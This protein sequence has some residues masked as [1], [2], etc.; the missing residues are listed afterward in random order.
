MS[1]S[2]ELDA[3]PS[4]IG[5]KRKK[6][7][8]GKEKQEEEEEAKSKEDVSE[9]QSHDQSTQ[10]NPCDASSP[11]QFW[12]WYSKNFDWNSFSLQQSNDDTTGGH[13]QNPSA[14]LIHGDSEPEPQTTDSLF[15][16]AK[17]VAQ[18]AGGT[19]YDRELNF[20]IFGHDT[21]E[22]LKIPYLY[23]R[24][25]RKLPAAEAGYSRDLELL[26]E[27]EEADWPNDL[28][29]FEMQVPNDNILTIPAQMAAEYFTVLSLHEAI[30]DEKPIL[31]FTDAEARNWEIPFEYHPEEQAFKNAIMWAVISH[32]H[33]LKKSDLILFYRPVPRLNLGHYLIEFDR[34]QEYED[35]KPEFRPENFLFPLQ[36]DQNERISLPR[37]EVLIHLPEVR[38]PRGIQKTVT[39]KL[40]DS[41][42][43][44][45][46]MDIVRYDVSSYRIV[47]GWE[48]FVQKHELGATDV[49]RF[50]K[51]VNPSHKKHFLIEI[52]KN[53]GGGANRSGPS[54]GCSSKRKEIASWIGC[55]ESG[56]RSV[57]KR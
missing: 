52:V 57:A 20:N 1:E 23:K 9:E 28:F 45:W 7:S 49:I 29:L 32:L 37:V 26:L 13:V 16:E 34:R 4:D 17:K 15:E 6:D 41:Q 21:A 19:G 14:T 50:Y 38:I 8:K 27:E 51:P 18:P 3:V 40:T 42:R 30:P 25:T 10:K 44:N 43:K 5:E 56:R 53:R 46:L 12:Q 39:I 24:A 55:G 11:I 48:E 2:G 36:L 31:Q 47:K 54:H 22:H 33:K 35:H